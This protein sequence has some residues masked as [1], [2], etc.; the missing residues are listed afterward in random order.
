MPA[1]LID[2]TEEITGESPAPA[3]GGESASRADSAV[4]GGRHRREPASW[5]ERAAQISP[6]RPVSG[7]V[8]RH[9]RARKS[10]LVVAGGPVLVAGAVAVSATTGTLNLSAAPAEGTEGDLGVRTGTSET[11]AAM[12]GRAGSQRA[13]RDDDRGLLGAL[14]E[15]LSGK[16][17]ES[18]RTS[19]EK[20]A[21]AS[22][23]TSKAESSAGSKSKSSAA[24]KSE[25]RSEA[26]SAK[27]AEKRTQ[28]APAFVRPLKSYRLTARFG[29]S[30]SRWSRDHTGLDFAA[31]YGSP[32]R[33]VAA[34][35]VVS[36]GWAGAYG[37]RTI[38]RH[39]DGTRTWYAHQ[40]RLLVRHGKVK[41]GQIIG[42]VGSTG[43]ST[44]PHMHLEVRR[45]G[46]PVDPAT[47]LRARGVYV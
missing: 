35:T 1:G 20:S 13:S 33:A 23:S 14:L 27:R 45:H 31:P 29:Q 37:Y 3:T 18:S 12:A 22:K 8:G 6:R 16:E 44:G 41:A 4:G 17:A 10:V 9:R 30:G 34:G 36:A 11:L 32:V 39:A 21:A 24:S 28:V 47:W 15:G 38:I 40:S 46:Q 5:S 25:S 2:R 19:P 43:N 7:T 42:R 26:K